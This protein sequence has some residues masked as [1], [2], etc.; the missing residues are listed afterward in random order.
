M[1][2]KNITAAVMIALATSVSAGADSDT[3][4]VPRG[5]D[6][7]EK[8]GPSILGMQVLCAHRGEIRDAARRAGWVVEFE[9]DEHDSDVYSHVL[10]DIDGQTTEI[11]YLPDGSVVRVQTMYPA[12]LDEAGVDRL[13]DTLLERYGEPRN[14]RFDTVEEA[15]V[16]RW[17]PHALAGVELERPAPGAPVVYRINALANELFSQFPMLFGLTD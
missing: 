11:T 16:I 7:V 6:C 9:N 13:I 10:A 2:I 8:H 3:C 5:D 15:F 12:E 17:L 14:A 4:T 1:N